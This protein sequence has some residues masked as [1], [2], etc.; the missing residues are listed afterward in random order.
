M[1]QERFSPLYL[2]SYATEGHAQCRVPTVRLLLR[3]W[4]TKMSPNSAAGFLRDS[5]VTV[6]DDAA[7][8]LAEICMCDKKVMLDVGN[9]MLELGRVEDT[10]G[11]LNNALGSARDPQVHTY[12]TPSLTMDYK[13]V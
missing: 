3:L 7:V 13:L 10:A 1:L 12:T 11:G 2:T 5:E 8:V 4:G 9:T 6:R